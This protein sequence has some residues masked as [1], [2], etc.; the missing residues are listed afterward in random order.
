MKDDPSTTTSPIAHECYYSV[1]K[2][3]SVLA[4]HMDER[5]EEC[6]GAKGWLL[7]SRRSLSW[8]IYLT[9]ENWQLQENGGGLRT[10]PQ[11]LVQKHVSSTHDGNLQV[12][13]LVPSRSKTDDNDDTVSVPVYLDSWFQPQKRETEPH[14]ILYTVAP[15]SRDTTTKVDQPIT[16]RVFLTQAWLSTALPP[17]IS[18]IDFIKA[19]AVKDSNDVPPSS[20]PSPP[21]DSS[22]SAL[23][24]SGGG[25]T[26]ATTTMQ[27]LFLN[28]E[29]ARQF[30][31]LE[32][33]QE[34]DEGQ[35]PRGC[36]VQDINPTRASLVVFDSVVLPH[37]V[38]AVKKGRRIAV[39]GWMHEATQP[40]PEDYSTF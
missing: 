29:F 19:W 25:A 34:W 18:I 5:H 22:D 36:R 14:C 16:D 40:F 20:S 30:A 2:Q 38:E 11:K 12:G 8:L 7:P 13:W 3:G 24:D 21:K 10:F 33:R 1:A 26:S 31:L 28:P 15:P 32:E 4:R 37:Q 6:K 23:K 17:G 27:G 35:L 39:A 9:D